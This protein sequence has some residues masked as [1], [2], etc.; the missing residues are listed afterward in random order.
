MS[1]DDR[2]WTDQIIGERMEL[3]QD[4]SQQVD[5]SQF[6]RQQWGLIMTATEFDIEDPGDAENARLVA[7]TSALPSVMP[8]LDRVGSQSGMAAMGDAGSDGTDD[9]GG[10]FLSDVANAL[11]LGGGEAEQGPGYSESEL[12]A[13]EEL[14]QQYASE[15]QERL[16]ERGKWDAVRNAASES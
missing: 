4:F 16:E 8:E 14:T 2:R 6:S 1:D 13:A 9:S 11:G 5:E 15:L 12:Q 7:D 3:D 10:G